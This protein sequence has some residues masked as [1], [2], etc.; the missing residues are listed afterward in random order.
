MTILFVPI[1]AALNFDGLS[2]FLEKLPYIAIDVVREVIKPKVWQI[3]YISTPKG[4]GDIVLNVI[5]NNF[6]LTGI[7]ILRVNLMGGNWTFPVTKYD[8]L[9]KQWIFSPN[10]LNFAFIID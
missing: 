8:E 7:K 5:I 6:R 3:T 10:D 2:T 1:D 9:K 4:F